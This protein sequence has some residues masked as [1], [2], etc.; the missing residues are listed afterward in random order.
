[1]L[2]CTARPETASP[3]EGTSDVPAK[4]VSFSMSVGRLGHEPRPTA[5]FPEETWEEL[6]APGDRIDASLAAQGVALTVG[7]E[8]TFT[9]RLHPEA[10]E[11]NGDAM[12][13]TKW[14]QGGALTEALR[15]RLARGA[16]ILHRYGKLYP[17]ESLPRWALDIVGRRDGTPLVK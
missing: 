14:E 15:A 9:S 6:P 3:T 1:P 11:W 16:V 10:P 13:P 12:G 4:E 7:G 17:G 8:P 2:A 5:P